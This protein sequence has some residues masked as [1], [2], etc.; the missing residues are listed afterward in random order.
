[1]AILATSSREVTLLEWVDRG[2]TAMVAIH[3]RDL[4][5]CHRELANLTQATI[6]LHKVVGVDHLLVPVVL[7][8]VGLDPN[9]VVVPPAPAAPRKEVLPK[10]TLGHLITLEDRGHLI[11]AR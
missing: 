1:M 6:H 3:S 10:D 8:P 4:T 11:L 9:K 5:V 7:L 2:A